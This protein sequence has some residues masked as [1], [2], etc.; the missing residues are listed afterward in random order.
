MVFVERKV[1]FFRSYLSN[2]KHVVK[3]GT[4]TSDIENINVGVPQGSLLGP[5]LFMLFVND[6]SQHVHLGTCNLY[7]DDC[8]VYCTGDNVDDVS[9]KLQQCVHDVS[10][11]YSENNLLLNVDKCNTMLIGSKYKLSQLNDNDKLSISL[12]DIPVSQVEVV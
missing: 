6:I 11:W 10:N 4:I 1:I 9:D 7:A 5:V 8:L 2:R 3:C 12:Q